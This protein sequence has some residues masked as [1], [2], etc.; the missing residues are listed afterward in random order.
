[1]TRV[2]AVVEDMFFASKIRATAEALGVEVSFPRT[3]QDVLEKVVET[4]PDLIVI[5]LHNQKFNAVEFAQGIKN[6]EQLRNVRL[7][8]FFSHVEAQLRRDA[9]S[10]GFDE[11]VPRSVFSQDL[12]GFLSRRSP[13]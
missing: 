7:L 2:I 11:V 3:Q 6:N 10:A 1:M 9:L 13:V 8:G 12:A 5:D 4:Q